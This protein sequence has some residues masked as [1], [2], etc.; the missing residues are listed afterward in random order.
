[1]SRIRNESEL[2][3]SSPQWRPS[4]TSSFRLSGMIEAAFM[5]FGWPWT[6]RP[7]SPKSLLD[8]LPVSEHLDRINAR[9]A[10]AWWHWFFFAQPEIPERVINADPDSWYLGDPNLMGQA[11]YQEWRA[12]LRDPEVV[13]GMLEDYRAGLTVD[14][15]DEVADRAL[16]RRVQPPLLVLWSTRDDL[17][18]LYGDPLAIWRSWATKVD[19]HGIDSGHHMAE[20][21]PIQLAEALTAFLIRVDPASR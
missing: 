13:R 12:V 6:I 9:F 2:A 3:T 15:Q 16:G 1:M 19:G 18:A 17:E 7:P 10:T 14:Y 5:P 11:N 20:L 21:A 8:C 4:D